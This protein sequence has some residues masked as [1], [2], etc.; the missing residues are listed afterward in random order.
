MQIFAD[1][2]FFE[3]Q[4]KCSDFC[5]KKLLNQPVG[6]IDRLKKK[7]RTEVDRCSHQTRHQEQASAE[8]AVPWSS[9]E[10]DSFL[11]AVAAI[12]DVGSAVLSMI[13]IVAV[14]QEQ[15]TA[16]VPAA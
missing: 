13:E 7:T 9:V 4:R 5:H 12:A 14:E 2:L 15:K 3:F 1:F 8:V 6:I 11:S 10:A 16:L